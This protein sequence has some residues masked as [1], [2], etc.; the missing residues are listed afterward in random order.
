M[1]ATKAYSEKLTTIGLGGGCHWCTEAIYSSLK[2]I[3]S[4]EQ[5]WIASKAPDDEFSEAVLVKIDEQQVSLQDVIEIHLNTHSSTSDHSMRKKYRSAVYVMSKMEKTKV[6]VLI[7]DLQK[8]FSERLITKALIF[9]D[10]K[11]SDDGYLDYF[12]KNPDKPF[13]KTYIQ[14]KINKLMQSY[15]HAVN[16]R[17]VA[18]E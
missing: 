11:K 18:H 2:G 17:K 16:Q 8:N 14:P 3:V 4:V 10:F 12:Y 7:E 6:Q 15:P 1:E 13:C 9:S 5:G